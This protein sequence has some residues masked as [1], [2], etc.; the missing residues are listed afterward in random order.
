MIRE[1]EPSHESF[2]QLIDRRLKEMG[3]TQL[4]LEARS[5]VADHNWSRWR[6]GSLPSR[7]YVRLAAPGLDVPPE[8]L[9]EIVDEDRRRA[10]GIRID[11]VPQAREWVD[12]HSQPTPAA[13]GG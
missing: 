5:G 1:C 13:Q 7:V 9:Q 3:I 11:T 6:K 4:E 8:R 12:T 2:A 10:A